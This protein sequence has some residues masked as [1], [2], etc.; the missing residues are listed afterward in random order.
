MQLD[1]GTLID[2]YRIEAPLGRGGIAVVYKARHLQLGTTHAIK[3]LQLPLASI[4]ERLLQEG[5]LQAR[6]S[7]PNVVHVTDVINVSGSPGL[8]MEFVDGPTLQQ[9]IERAPPTLE[10]IDE[11][12]V[13]V[14]RGVAV[15]HRHGLIHRDLKP[16]NVMIAIGEDGIVPKVADFGMAKLFEGDGDGPG[17]GTRSGS[18]LGTPCYMAPEQIRD[19]KHV[20]QRADVW[21]LGAI[22]YELVT[23]RRA[24]DGPDVLAIFEVV[25][26]GR[27]A[28]VEEVAPGTPERMCSAIR[29]AL[30]VDRDA[31]PR[32]VDALLALWRGVA[33]QA[34]HNRWDL[35]RVRAAVPLAQAATPA[36]TP[37]AGRTFSVSSLGESLPLVSA[38]A[39]AAVVTPPS[40][41]SPSA[42]SRSTIFGGVGLL[43]ALA[44]A[45]VLLV[46][47][48]VVAGAAG[49]GLAVFGSGIA[50]VDAPPAPVAVV[51]AAPVVVAPPVV[52]APVIVASPTVVTTRPVVET[53]P[54]VAPPPPVEVTVAE[55]E[56]RTPSVSS[57]EVVV[58]AKGV[59]VWL[60]DAGGSRH[61]GGRLPVGSYRIVATGSN[62]A[63]FGGA[64]SL[65]VVDGGS[66]KVK[67]AAAMGLC[68]VSK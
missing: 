18:T 7:H 2:R 6:L 28:P 48:A 23:G 63:T 8:V 31:R 39:S 61:R 29:A 52:A 59:D 62:G 67:C 15:A 19:A 40:T 21:A 38:S 49:A 9:L 55:P 22:L 14:M 13:G 45:A 34:P 16:A 64:A 24:F 41:A 1:A 66:V 27:Y 30:T 10:Q 65:E 50:I 43:V 3:V 54:V 12:A 32:D 36:P 11:L 60:E 58:D 37:P 51:P 33:E 25:A 56:P 17:M 5:R 47:V 20:D 44:L 68:S 26:A 4:Q 35:D 42:G 57:G 46:A 53:R